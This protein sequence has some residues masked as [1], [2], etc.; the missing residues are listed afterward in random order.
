M[1]VKKVCSLIVVVAF[2]GLL[3]C[4][5]AGAAF[6]A[7]QVDA[8]ACAENSATYHAWVAAQNMKGAG[9]DLQP[10]DPDSV[11]PFVARLVELIGPPTRFDPS[12]VDS[13]ELARTSDPMHIVVRFVAADTCTLGTATISLPTLNKVQGVIGA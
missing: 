10:V 4:V 12:L 2:F 1:S 9:I 7:P 3:V 8:P 5:L 6:S 13:I 11:A